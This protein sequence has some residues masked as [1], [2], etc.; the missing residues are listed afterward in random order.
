M[1]K[2][3]NPNIENIIEDK[4]IEEYIKMIKEHK[5]YLNKKIYNLIFTKTDLIEKYK[6]EALIDKHLGTELEYNGMYTINTL[7][8]DLNEL[9]ISIIIKIE[10]EIY[11]RETCFEIYKK[12]IKNSLLRNQMNWINTLSENFIE[13][14]IKEI[15][16]KELSKEETSTKIDGIKDDIQNGLTNIMSEYQTIFNQSYQTILKEYIID[17][18]NQMKK[19]ISETKITHL[20]LPKLKKYSQIME[21]SNYE[22]IEENNTFYARNKETN[23]KTELILDEIKLKSR[24]DKIIFIVDEN[25]NHQGYINNENHIRI[26]IT[27]NRIDILI[28]SN[29]EQSKEKTIITIN[30]VNND[31]EF[32]HN[33]KITKNIKNIESIINIIA[34]Y[35]PGIYDKLLY[36]FHFGSVLI[37]IKEYHNQ[38]NKTNQQEKSTNLLT[39]DSKQEE[40]P[41]SKKTSR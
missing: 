8:E 36:D 19:Q 25:T 30:K 18:M 40:E 16:H 17:K 31:Y 7:S 27:N 9:S 39:E 24:D 23:E 37:A 1:D 10:K 41:H 22:L 32:Y 4:F 5:K 2:F 20:D 12:E 3:N 26:V 15:S 13:E 11:D 21:H 38:Q 28:A 6:I 29:K 35:T 33:L 14:F 34:K